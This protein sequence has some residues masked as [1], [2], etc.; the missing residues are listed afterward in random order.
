MVA[1]VGGKENETV[2]LVV[3]YL[4]R[5]ITES[6][7]FTMQ[8]VPSRGSFVATACLGAGRA[9]EAQAEPEVGVGRAGSPPFI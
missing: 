6:V 1:P 2:I 7:Y 4:V 8:H 9:S 5:V 3:I